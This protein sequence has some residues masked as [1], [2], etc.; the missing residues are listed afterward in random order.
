MSWAYFADLHLTVS[1]PSWTRLAER[2]PSEI[3][4]KP[5]W[6]ALSDKALEEA[7]GAPS[8]KQGTFAQALA[9]E[10]YR[11][12]NTV[13]RIVQKG[14]KTTVRVCLLLD[15]SV[16][17]LAYPLAT[18]LEAAR[19]DASA[20]G[21]LR[22]VNDG[23]YSGEEGAELTLAKGRLARKRIENASLLVE[24]LTEEIFSK[25]T[26]GSVHPFL[27]KP[28]SAAAGTAGAR[29]GVA[30]R[31][32]TFSAKQIADAAASTGALFGLGYSQRRIADAYPDPEKLAKAVLSGDKTL[33]KRDAEQV[34]SSAALLLVELDDAAGTP[35]AVALLEDPDQPWRKSAVDALAWSQRDEALLALLAGET[36]QAR[37]FVGGGLGRSRH[38]AAAA[39]VF[40]RVALAAKEG[41]AALAGATGF[42][43][44]LGAKAYEPARA[45]LQQIAKR[46][47]ELYVREAAADALSKFTSS[48]ALADA[49]RELGSRNADLRIL[50]VE[51]LFRKDAARAYEQ[52]ERYF[53]TDTETAETTLIALMRHREWF[54]A[55]PRWKALC[56]RLLTKDT[57]LFFDAW[58]LLAEGGDVRADA[59][60]S[61]IGECPLGSE[62]AQA[63][64][65]LPPSALPVI[66]AELRR[67]E[68]EDKAGKSKQKHKGDRGTLRN[69][70]KHL[71]AKK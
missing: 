59:V 2:K 4:L 29:K 43:H 13:H 61:M 31:L 6:S 53:D 55:D 64:F 46:S 36:T 27:P 5:G 47:K 52:L 1:T 38:P 71:S 14:A 22:L 21:T 24:D 67:R 56:G 70:I 49:A 58:N 68:E 17:D 12:P 19:D 69:V 44:A 30:A 23:T 15:K 63:L 7:L 8:T 33:G 62:L 51:S 57:A 45:L 37:I 10:S 65:L 48:A 18:L 35:L 42:I 41:D 50:A 20:K 25:E 16:L 28:P 40:E 32:A 60:L 54:D 34:K 66:E 3:S 11:G 9:N 39:R 26:K